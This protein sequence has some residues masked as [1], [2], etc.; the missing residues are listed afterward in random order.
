MSRTATI[1]K[2]VVADTKEAFIMCQKDRTIFSKMYLNTPIKMN[3]QQKL[4]NELFEN[5][6]VAVKSAHD[7]GKTFTFSDAV[8]EALLVDG[9]LAGGIYI[10]VTAPTYNLIKNVFFAE[11][12]NKISKS[13][14]PLGLKVNQT[15]IR[16]DDKWAVIGFSPKLAAEGDTSAFQG[17]HA[18]I[19]IV[20][21]EEATGVD[22]SIWNMAEGMTTSDKVYM[23]AI[24]NPTDANSEFAKCFTNP[25]WHCVTWPCFL[26]PNLI[27]NGVTDIE[28][29]RAEAAVMASLPDEDKI[30]RL[31][32]YT[33]VQP[34]LLT[35][36]WVVERYLEWGEESPLFQGKALAQFPDI[37]EDTLFTI[38]RLEECMSPGSE[39]E[40]LTQVITSNIES[41]GCDVARF[42]TD[43]AVIF[44]FRGNVETRK[45]VY[46][47]KETTFISGRLIEIARENL[48]KDMETI[49]TVDEGAMGAGVVDQLRNHRLIKENQ[50]FIHVHAVNFG[51]DAINLERYYNQAAEMYVLAS[52]QH[53]TDSG[54]ILKNDEN[55]LSELTARKYKFDTD[56]RF[57]LEKKEDF[58]KRIGHSPDL[59]DAFVLAFYH[60]PVNVSYKPYGTFSKGMA[61]LPAVHII[62]KSRQTGIVQPGDESAYMP[63]SK[64]DKFFKDNQ[65]TTLRD[66]VQ[67]R[68]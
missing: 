56:G 63:G 8:I 16:L 59:A 7:L 27:A 14:V 37:S 20:I 66:I 11:I 1:D 34:Q 28:K 65:H 26:S 53:K 67:R 55:L 19:V 23:W 33:V 49:L 30:K 47:K 41:I 12:R 45:E 17:F 68:Y 32:A 39:Q 18:P 10:I 60:N 25:F 21:F 29:L 46:T 57:V 38:R 4:Y 35:L 13:K 43:R 40:G 61:T 3:Y 50:K 24:G 6:R 54:F 5:R 9:T 2:Q 51:G 42:G 48:A 15:E 58:K 36:R 44:G 62:D 22:K 31:T 64:M 52:M